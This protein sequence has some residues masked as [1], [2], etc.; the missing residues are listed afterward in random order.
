VHSLFNLSRDAMTRRLVRALSHPRVHVLGHPTGRLLGEREPYAL[1]M[2]QVIKAAR[3]HGV[4]L[5]VNAQPHRLDLSDVNI[6]MAREAGVPLVISTDA[7]RIAELDWM[8]F[9]VDQARRGWC[10]ARDIANTRRLTA[11]RKMLRK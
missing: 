4:M 3:E 5:E 11:F 9:G 7:H 1:D 8:R 6:A 10:S 2:P